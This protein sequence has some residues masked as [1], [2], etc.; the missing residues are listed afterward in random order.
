MTETAK[1]VQT[2]ETDKALLAEL[3]ANTVPSQLLRQELTEDQVCDYTS[4]PEALATTSSQGCVQSFAKVWS[5][6]QIRKSFLA[7]LL[8]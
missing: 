7:K 3:Q 8:G 1:I 6:F 5:T 2:T 4:V